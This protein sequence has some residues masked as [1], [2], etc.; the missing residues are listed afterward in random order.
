MFVD[1]SGIYCLY[2]RDQR[3]HYSAIEFYE[4]ARRRV[5][6]NYVLA[7]YIALSDKHGSSRKDAIDFSQRVLDDDEIKVVWVSPG[8]HRQAV[9]LLVDRD[10]KTYS[11]CDAVSFIV[12]R[13]FGITDALTTDRHFKQ[14]GFVRLLRA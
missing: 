3:D 1:T 14:E 4:L 9:Q 11:L 6:T 2:N 8:L 7:E 5:T 12:M 13:D 10:D